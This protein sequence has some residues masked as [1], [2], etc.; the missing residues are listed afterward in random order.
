VH[1]APLAFPSCAPPGAESPLLT[2]GTPDAN[3]ARAQSVASARFVARP[4]DSSTAADEAD[5]TLAVRAS[6]V[7]CAGSGAACPG[8]SGS[9]FEGRLLLRATLRIT[10]R[11]NGS[12]PLAQDDPATV[13]DFPLQ[14][15]I[16]CTATEPGIGS[17]CAL[18]TTLD[19]LFP[20]AV[21]EGARAI[22]E[23]GA[24]ELDDPGPNGTGY[25][26]GCGPDCGDGDESPFMRQGVFAP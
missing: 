20:G 25:A 22:W 5:V 24:A 9:D 13:S 16:P 8:G 4:G 11:T 21:R 19:A 10:D 2:V 14:V 6:D 12:T 26:D 7:R 17:A 18:E 15:P 3:G 1:V 23:V